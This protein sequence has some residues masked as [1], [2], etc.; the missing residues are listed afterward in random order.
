Q[1]KSQNRNSPMAYIIDNENAE[2]ED[3]QYWEHY[4]RAGFVIAN[5]A[6][7]HHRGKVDLDAFEPM[8]I[9]LAFCA[10][11][12]N[13]RDQSQTS[14]SK[15]FQNIL[16]DLF[17]VV[18]SEACRGYLD[19]AVEIRVREA[20]VNSSILPNPEAQKHF[21]HL[22]PLLERSQ[23]SGACGEDLAKTI[24]LYSSDLEISLRA[25]RLFCFDPNGIGLINR[26]GQL[27]QTC[28]Q[29]S[30][31][32]DQTI[33]EIAALMSM[34]TPSMGKIPW[35][36]THGWW[37]EIENH[38]SK[39]QKNCLKIIRQILVGKG[40]RGQPKLVYEAARLCLATF[41]HVGND[42]G[43]PELLKEVLH[44]LQDEKDKH[45][46][47]FVHALAPIFSQEAAS[48]IYSDEHSGEKYGSFKMRIM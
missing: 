7:S 32:I 8:V 15:I 42:W 26:I 27:Y 3:A 35:S 33:L 2:E 5:H 46:Y 18:T 44:Q 40:E 34:H 20:L 43:N 11:K 39:D 23:T 1:P 4:C 29:K 6:L 24:F 47:A 30:A 17:T 28:L 22:I 19:T 31:A 13:E 14:V 38:V 37:D 9:K 41:F 10:N 25:A 16:E 21:S 48:I 45:T 12:G 36:M